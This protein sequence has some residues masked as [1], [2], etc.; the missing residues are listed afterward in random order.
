MCWS[1]PFGLWISWRTKCIYTHPFWVVWGSSCGV[2]RAP[3]PLKTSCRLIQSG[4]RSRLCF[5]SVLPHV[6]MTRLV[7]SFL[8][9]IFVAVILSVFSLS[10]IALIHVLMVSL[11]DLNVSS[12]VLSHRRVHIRYV[13]SDISIHRSLVAP[14]LWVHMLFCWGFGVLTIR[15]SQPRVVPMFIGGQLSSPW[16]HKHFALFHTSSL[17]GCLHS[18]SM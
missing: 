10:F 13:A 6:P 3:Y 7:C 14:L 12:M 9:N 1:G 18:V 8:L 11:Q 5:L 2:C 15:V 16:G 4:G 17:A